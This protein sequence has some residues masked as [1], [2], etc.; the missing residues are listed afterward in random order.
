MSRRT[1][2]TRPKREDAKRSARAKATTC[3]YR[4]ARRDKEAARG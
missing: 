4:K 2:F 3:A 1:Y